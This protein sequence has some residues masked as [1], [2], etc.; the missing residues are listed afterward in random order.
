MFTILV[1]FGKLFQFRD[2]INTK[3]NLGED[4][5]MLKT[6][7]VETFPDNGQ[8]FQLL[9]WLPVLRKKRKTELKE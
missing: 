1:P 7:C 4:R 5:A 9:F 2:T 8:V 6:S 3:E